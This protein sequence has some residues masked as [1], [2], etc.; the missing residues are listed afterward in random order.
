MA[1]PVAADDPGFAPCARVTPPTSSPPSSTVVVSILSIK[2]NSD[3]EGDD[4][5]VPFYDNHADIYGFVTIAGETFSLP[6]VDENDFPHWDTNG[7]FRKVVSGG[8][9]HIAIDI[10][11]S[12][13]GI[14]GDD[15]SVD[16]SPVAGKDVLDL[17]YD[18]CSL[19]VSGD[20]GDVLGQTQNVITV[21]AGNDSD[22]ATIRFKVE[23]EDGRP[24]TAQDLAL[25]DVDLVQVVNHQ[26][27]IVAG[28]PT[29][30][31][32][33]LASNYTTDVTTSLRVEILGGISVDQTF[34][35]TI[36]HGEVKKFDFFTDTP[37]VFPA[38]GAPYIP[39]VKVSVVDP[40]SAPPGDCRH[41]N[42]EFVSSGGPIITA[43]KVRSVSAPGA[44][45]AFW[46]VVA[47]QS[48]HL[49]W[50]PVGTLLDIGNCAGDSSVATNR[51]LG[52]AFIKGTYPVADVHNTTNPVCVIPPAS[53]AFDFLA[54][55][56]AA[57]GLPADAVLPFVLVFELNGLAAQLALEP[58]FGVDRVIGILPNNWF[59]RFIEAPVIN[60]PW[61][62]VTGLSLGEFAPHAVILMASADGD[63]MM[64][65][66]A[67]ELG[68]TYGLSVATEIKSWVCDQ[69]F[70]GDIDVLAC[71]ATGGFDEYKSTLPIPGITKGKP[72]NGYWTPQGGEPASLPSGVFGEQC[73]SHCLM[74]G[75][76]RDAEN[77]WPSLKR[78][79]D[80]ADYDRVLRKLSDSSLF[81]LR[82]RRGVSPT[83][84]TDSIYVSGMIAYDDRVYLGPWYRATG[85][86]P[87]RTD[88]FG[89][90]SL[91]FK[92]AS[93][94]T[95]AEVGIPIDWNTP[96]V[97][98]G[99]PIT[100]FG[101]FVPYPSG[102][103]H[104]DVVNTQTSGVLVTQEVSPHAP[105][106]Q[107]T[108]PTPGQV[109]EGGCSIRIAWQASDA[110]G[111]PLAF[112]VLVKPALGNG[113]P[114]AYGLTAP[115]Y[116]LDV[117]ALPPGEYTITVLAA[118]GVNV[119][120][121]RP[122]TFTLAPPGAPDTT[123]PTIDVTLNRTVLWPPNHR[124]ADIV[125]S[126]NVHD[127]C[128]ASA[129]F[130]LTSIT[131]DEPDDRG[132]GGHT[133]DDI[134]GAAFG[135][136]DVAFQLRAERDG[137][138]D[139]RTY[140]ITYTALDASGNAATKVVYVT[141]PHDQHRRPRQ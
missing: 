11:E 137:H 48:P 92:D 20:I 13:G 128:D 127:A 98:G 47:T 95:L 4:D 133:G 70:P 1:H 106:V 39:F 23:L 108:A 140:T 79:V 77:H 132:G 81:A 121:S 74:G 60:D 84:P 7:V 135:T 33:R 63:P 78:W 41:D 61:A 34:P 75:S 102:T 73:D 68:H 43:A 38:S 96:D 51:D 2:P 80:T 37:L 67:H 114:A 118:D 57:F 115:E 25:V 5:H 53:A 120:K 90:Y 116:R 36:G 21:K 19:R 69:D 66:P 62:E 119:G 3:L 10:N 55:V 83:A 109:L 139:G 124:M 45:E 35:V 72:S 52:T 12:D 87:D 17:D 42:D 32:V 136:P 8:P 6:K 125:A 31:R 76:P 30:L 86:P 26:A 112:T 15:D 29:I 123:P 97:R 82:K 64:T 103:D 111:D 9:V 71:G 131:S 126:V 99:V 122:V 89:L 91:R 117:K 40:N 110:D 28:K 54:T 134:Q 44:A 104:V 105:E 130:V 27:N 100:F 49:L 93:G 141:V 65:L 59:D 85:V 46:Q 22:D 107:I 101:L 16:V 14:T 50:T 113:F 56:L 58:V 88:A 138:G 129:R 94:L 24:V 18:L